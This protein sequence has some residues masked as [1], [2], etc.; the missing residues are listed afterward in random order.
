MFKTC[1]NMLTHVKGHPF[2]DKEK[3]ISYYTHYIISL[4]NDSNL[5]TNL[6]INGEN[7]VSKNVGYRFRLRNQ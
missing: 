3:I 7:R 5:I 4:E 2:F 1:L 6:T